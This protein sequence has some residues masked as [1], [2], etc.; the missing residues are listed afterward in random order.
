MSEYTFTVDT[1]AL[2][3][4]DCFKEASKEELRVLLTVI[5]ANSSAVSIE[6]LSEM[7]EVSLARTKAAITL[8]EECGIIKKHENGFSLGEIVYEFA[9][10]E[11]P[12][13]RQ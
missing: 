8:F 10:N 12:D 3:A 11:N 9:I 4:S 2:L 1:S 7:A 6:L 5:A 13:K